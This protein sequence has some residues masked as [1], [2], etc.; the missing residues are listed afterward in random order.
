LGDV[1]AGGSTP[2]VKECT[3]LLTRVLAV[4]REG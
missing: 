4:L 3:S 2:S 1:I